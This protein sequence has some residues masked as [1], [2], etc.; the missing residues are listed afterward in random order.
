[1]KRALIVF[2]VILVAFCA[3]AAFAGETKPATVTLSI[4][5]MHCGGCA[6][7]ITSML[8]RT[9]GVIKAVVSFEEKSATVDYDSGKTS[10][11]KIIETVE[12]MGFKVSV[13][14]K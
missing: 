1:M 10:P 6:S 9:A 8:K 4:G 13:K 14:S 3:V 5:G 12:N 7:G 2:A 11:A